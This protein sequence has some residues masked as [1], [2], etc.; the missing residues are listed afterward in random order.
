MN[1]LFLIIL[2]FTSQITLGQNLVE[3]TFKHSVTEGFSTAPDF[4]VITVKNSN[5]GIIKEICT[6]VT[7]L[8]WSLQ[9]EY[10]QT[11][12]SIVTD[13]LLKHST[14]R[15][16]ALKNKKALERL[17]FD[18][19]NNKSIDKIDKLIKS[20]KLV[21]SLEKLAEYRSKLS[22]KFYIYQDTRAD[23]I[24][25]IRDSISNIRELSIEE[26]EMLNKLDDQYYDYHYNEYYWNKLSDKGKELIKIWN[27][28]IKNEKDKY[29]KIE[30]ELERQNKKFFQK[31]YKK[32]GI[33]FCHALFLN[34][35]TCYQDCEN[36]EVNFGKVI[37]KND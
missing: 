7:S 20:K 29:S 3:K 25:F 15:F 37:T 8:Y 12:Y 35:V 34:G 36:G 18:K 9:E 22:D 33:N 27:V 30:R 32:Y 28:T 19:Y 10:N 13:S 24:D 6:D 2:I 26:K 17:Y 5:N 23:K 31:Y 14:D 11:D 16:F 1:R 21:D 4:V